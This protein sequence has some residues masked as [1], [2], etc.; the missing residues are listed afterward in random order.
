MRDAITIEDDTEIDMPGEEPKAK[1]DKDITAIYFSEIGRIR[2]L[3]SREKE[4]KIFTRREQGI[5]GI[6]RGLISTPILLQHLEELAPIMP[7]KKD[8]EDYPPSLTQKSLE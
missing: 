5:L 7:S 6:I 1:K 3:N 4:V 8:D 2:L